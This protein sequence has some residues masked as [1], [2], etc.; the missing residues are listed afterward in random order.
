MSRANIF[1]SFALL[2]MLFNISANA[3]QYITV[4]SSA[5]SAE[6]L[7]RDIFIGSQNSGCITVS[8]VSAKGWQN[9]GSSSSSYGYFEKGTLP[10][11]INKGIILS[12]GS[13]QNA[14]GPNNVL[15][16]DQDSNW[17]G[18]QDLA[19]ALQESV[20]NYLN[21]T[22]IEFDF[23]ASNTSGISFE[24]LFLSEEYRRTNCTYSDG[25]AFLIKKAGSSD[26]Y[27]NIALVPGTQDPVTSLTINTAPNCPRNTAYF[28]S[29]NGINSPT[30]FDGQTKVLTAKTDII[31]GVKYH[32]K[33]VIA[34][35]LAGSDRTGRYDSAV[36]LK[37]G[38][39]VGK[40]DLGPDLLIST[41]NPV[42][43]GSSKILDATTAGATSYQWFKNGISISGA[44]QPQLSIP[45]VTASNGNYGV[46]VNVGGCILTGSV[47]IEIQEKPALN[48]GTYYLCDDNLSGSVP[49]DFSNLDSQI[50]SNFNSGYQPKYYLEKSASQ[51]G[52][53]G[54]E[55][56]NGWLL[57]TDTPIYIR[58]E[59][60]FG[61]N[62]EFGEIIL[63][64]GNKTPLIT[65]SF[66]DD[67][68]DNDR[69]GNITI[70]LKNYQTRFTSSAQ[71]NVT[72]YNSPQD[73]RNKVN[74]IPENQIISNSKVFGI[75]IESLSACPNV[76][77]LSLNFKSPKKS[78]DLKDKV[79]CSNATTSLDAGPGFDS[80]TW[81][82]GETTQEIN[83]VGIGQYWV[84]L[85]SNG[86]LYRQTVKVTAAT[87]PQITNIDVSGNTATV[88]VSGGL[89]PYEYSLDNITFQ[90]SNVFTHIP[91]GL[92]KIYV[93]DAKKCQTVEKEFLI[94]NLIN[95]ITPN[96]DGINDVLDYSDLRIKDNVSLQIFDRFGTLVF[97]SKEN[98]FIW[99][100]KLSGRTLP[101]ANYWY[102]LNW[103]EPDTQIPISYKGW[104]LLKNRN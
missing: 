72:F 95:V 75:R 56:Q 78:D 47:Q 41:N 50:I 31:P 2:F 19:D 84:D 44:T 81:S 62:P 30:A 103:T 11:D 8:N 101:T 10:F 27:T 88:F 89:Q 70:D 49:V 53:P 28:G 74:P 97:T 9:F 58:I 99:D 13:I 48:L 17:S 38:S 55:L 51:S 86:C 63:K 20:W 25:F 91:R 5:Y 73:A 57:T 61:C 100:G 82:T 46:E 16:D 45:G 36:F 67:V 71:A 54:T 69:D 42:C 77:T 52:T 85:G 1:S 3:Q 34:D 4:D 64:I 37:A 66:S 18:D 26:P 21:A 98:Q 23:V 22:S 14:P 102:V 40:K 93:R 7:V 60:A 76:A 90:N 92:Q 83:N 6:E 68:C 12:T 35:H 65:N 87:L 80:Y 29:F 43:E 96:G 94:I 15:L 39:F 104:I 24:Y 33:L 32:I 79:I 59:S